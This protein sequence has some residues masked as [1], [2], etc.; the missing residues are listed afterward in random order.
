[1]F[2]LLFY[3]FSFTKLESRRA[4]QILCGGELG[5]NVGEVVVGKGIGG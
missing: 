2:L 1:M 4:E 5:A 3:V